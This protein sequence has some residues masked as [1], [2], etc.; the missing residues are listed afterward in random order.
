MALQKGGE[1][2]KPLK[3]F[4][5]SAL[6]AVMKVVWLNIQAAPIGTFFRIAALVVESGGDVGGLARQLFLYAATVVSALTLHALVTLPLLFVLVTWRSPL[7][8][9]RTIL[10]I[11]STIFGTG[12]SVVTLPVSLSCMLKDG[13]V[14]ESI[15]SFV[16]PVGASL[17]F[18]GTS[19]Y[20]AVAVIF[21]AQTYG[22][23]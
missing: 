15:V 9:M 14:D 3:A 2:S 23:G 10:G 16:L 21:V 4:F 22:K 6:A 8:F 13:M 18:D 19:L 11:V 20:E 12:S 17:N 7:R 1:R 5:S